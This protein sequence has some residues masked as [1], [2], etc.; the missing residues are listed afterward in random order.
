MKD[1]IPFSDFAKIDLRVGEV[2]EVLE[3]VGSNKLW[4]LTVDFGE[5]LGKKT[6]FSGIKQWYSVEN[7]LH[8]KLFFVV[9]LEPK[10]FKIGDQECVSDGMLLAAGEQTA[11]LYTIDQDL[12][13]GSLVH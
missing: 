5:E 1:T 12:V 6:I 13:P 10:K 9:N 2:V 7:L 8:R 3:V 11:A 4:N